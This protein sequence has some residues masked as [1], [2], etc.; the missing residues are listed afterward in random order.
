M[1]LLFCRISLGLLGRGLKI[2]LLFCHTV[3][4]GFGMRPNGLQVC[5]EAFFEPVAAV[6]TS[7]LVI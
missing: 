7:C 4:A 6:I 5:L 3:S 1:L 2:E